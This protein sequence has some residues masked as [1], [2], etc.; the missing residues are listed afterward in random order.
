MYLLI[1]FIFY[2]NSGTLLDYI[3]LYRNVYKITYKKKWYDTN[4]M[5]YVMTYLNVHSFYKTLLSLNI[6][7]I[8]PFL[9]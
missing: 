1:S 8:I 3:V 9:N 2:K 7:Y 6:I 5:L 4:F